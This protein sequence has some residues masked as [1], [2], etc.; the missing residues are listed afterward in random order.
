MSSF[1]EVERFIQL[2]GVPKAALPFLDRLVSQEEM[3]LVLAAEKDALSLDSARQVLGMDAEGAAE[4]LEGAFRRAVLDREE[5]EGRIVYVP[6][7]LYTRLEYFATFDDSWLEIPPDT[8]R[9]LDEWMLGQY[10]ERVLPDVEALLAASPA[11]VALGNGD[12]ALVDELDAIVDAAHTIV[13]VPCGCRR[14]GG[15]CNKP[16]E[17]CIQLDDAAEKKLARGYGR[18]LTAAEAKK[19]I[20][21]T[22]RKGLIHTTDLHPGE[23]R[24]SH[25]CACCADDC[26]AFRAAE[27]LGSQGVWP[28]SRYVAAHDIEK[29]QHCGACIQR[30][31]FGAFHRDGTMVEVAGLQV[32]KVVLDPSLCR[33]CGLCTASC[34]LDAITLLPAG[35]SRQ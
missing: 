7:D 10:V 2:F 23:Q 16:L 24:P 15:H 3:R 17:M 6:I 26:H 28:R 27:R 1:T 20:R 11:Q 35:E 14:I 32:Q 34:F 30:C 22:D 4:V 29:C 9:V 8:R 33:G 25:I 18:Q 5:R 12:V 31:H 19:L 21:L 13:V